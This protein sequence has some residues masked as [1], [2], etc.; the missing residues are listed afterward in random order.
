M[1]WPSIC[2]WTVV[3]RSD[4]SVATY[5]L[6]SSIGVACAGAITT[7]V[8]GIACPRRRPRRRAVARARHGHD[9]DDSA[10]LAPHDSHPTEI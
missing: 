10:A 1:I 5:S 3:E 6:A 2:G 7:G 4:F 9:R 8:G